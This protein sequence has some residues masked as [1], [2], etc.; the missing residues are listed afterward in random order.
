MEH[1]SAPVY[2]ITGLAGA[3]KTTLAHGL[4]AHLRARGQQ[5]VLLDGDAVREILGETGSY[6]LSSRQ[7]VAMRISHLCHWLSEQ[8]IPVVCATISLFHACQNWN[9]QHMPGYR[10][11]FLDVPLETLIARDQKGLYSA[12][13][14]GEISNVMGVDLTPEWPQQPDWVLKDSGEQDPRSILESL[15][16]A[17][18]L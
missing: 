6:D 4:Q 18:K 1:V 12:A 14:R 16:V 15:L 7:R 8:G 3:G 11:I 17:L 10:E 9:R 13:L 5:A 2:W